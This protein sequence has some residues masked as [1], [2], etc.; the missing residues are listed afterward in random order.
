MSLSIAYNNFYNLFVVY[1]Y[2]ENHKNI[3]FFTNFL[4]RVWESNPISLAYEANV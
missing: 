2:D 3:Q 4:K 1:K